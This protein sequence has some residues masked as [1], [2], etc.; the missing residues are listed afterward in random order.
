MFRLPL[1]TALAF[2]AAASIPSQTKLLRHPDIHQDQVV[3][4]YAGDLWR[5]PTAG[6]NAIRL[7][8]TP[9]VELFAKFSPDGRWIAFTGQ[10]NGD[11]QVCVVPSEGGEVRQLTWYPATGPLPSR[12][13]YDNQVYGW[14]PDGS[15]VLFRS[16]RAA[17]TLTGGKLFTV[18]LPAIARRRGA[19]PVPLPMP[20]AGAGDFSPDGERIV[21]APLFRDF[22]TWKRYQ[23]GWAQE[24]FI[25]DPATGNAENIS[26]HVRTDRD[27]MWIGERIWFA[28]DRTGTLNLWSYDLNNKTVHQETSSNMWDLR[29]PSAGSQD[30]NRIVYE[31]GGELFW[32]DTNTRQ[33]TAIKIRVPDEGDTKRRQRVD[34]SGMI[35]GY[36]LSPGGRRAVFS[37]RGDLLTV[38]KEHGDVRNLSNSPGAHDKHPTFSPDGSTIAFVS[39]QS[40]E[41]QLWLVD[42]AGLEPARQLTKGLTSMLY[43]GEWS[44][45]AKW[46]AVGDKDGVLRV[47]EVATG[48]LTVIADEP[49]GQLRDYRWSPCSGHL[50]FS[51][52]DTTELSH[53]YIW[54]MQAKTLRLVSRAMSNDSYPVWGP[55]GER[56]FFRGLRGFQPRLAG[57]YEWDFQIDR[58]YGL[59]AL[60][61]QKDLPALF[62]QRSDE[63][64]ADDKDDAEAKEKADAKTFDSPINIDFEGLADRVETVPLPLDNYWG[65]SIANGNLLYARRGGSY[66]G[67][68]S[69]KPTTLHAFSLKDRKEEQ[70]A[71]GIRGYSLSA[72]GE[73]TMIAVGGKFVITKASPAGKDKQHPLDVSGLQTD[74]V[75]A[76][77]YWQIF[78]EVWR[79]YRDFF[80]VANMHGHDW[81]ALRDQY[82]PLVAHVRHRSD[83][84]YVIGEMI[85]EL[86]VGHA[87]ISGGDLGA[88]PRPAA[89]LP[90]M[91]LRFDS[92]SRRYQIAKILKGENDHLTYRSPA[93]AVGVHL[94]EGDYLLAIDGRELAPDTNPYELLQGKAGRELRLLVNDRPSTDSARTVCMQTIASE[95]KLHYLAWVNYNRDRVAKLSGGKLGY[96]HLPDMG[97]NGIREFLKQYYPQ[98][99]KLGLVVDDRYNGGGNVSEMVINRLQRELMMCT[100]GR[101]SGFE[102][103][104]RAVF[105]G[106]MVCLLNETSASD[107]DIFPAMFRRAKLGKLIGKRSWGGII[108][109]TNRGTLLDGGTVNVPEFGNTEPGPKWTIEGY[110]VDPDIEVDNDLA[111][112]LRGEDKQL[113]KAVEVLLEQILKAPPVIPTAPPAPVK[114]GR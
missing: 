7:T 98:R 84:N 96:V 8:A 106:H 69:D 111:S 54:S 110:G 6:G 61:L 12:W 23:G 112:V 47:C 22:R 107:G 89:A 78:H 40:G 100:F 15:A 51:M 60:A 53:I 25:F 82:A 101:T 63:A 41:E 97:E 48:E 21:Y 105:H 71:S 18:A 99:D 65:L 57:V 33:E 36:D 37:A 85:A 35:E 20:Q 102:S 38:P 70:L 42:H 87:Y 50:A 83:L 75:A 26:N 95:Q 29:W 3:F 113:E 67:R 79:R 77:E 88:P 28:S 114:T 90:G 32:L 109:I 66:Y 81:Q 34:A 31:K 27:P 62:G 94:N 14:T 76:D 55:T 46:L 52:S 10:I 1:A 103:Y 19:L 59:F 45:D 11:E 17:W 44:P 9:G 93:T 64:V 16:L 108:G 74:K 91:V 2:A 4:T 30:E 72:D 13:G 104:P 58:G 92:Q 24:L 56:L 80:Y 39:D 86:G 5:A 43:S 68:G 49:R 73:H